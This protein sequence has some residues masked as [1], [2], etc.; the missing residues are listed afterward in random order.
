MRIFFRE[1]EKEKETKR[2]KVLPISGLVSQVPLLALRFGP[3]AR[4]V[5]EGE[6]KIA[7]RERERERTVVIVECI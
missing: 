2:P 1:K 7:G 4:E 5:E 3:R 6:Q